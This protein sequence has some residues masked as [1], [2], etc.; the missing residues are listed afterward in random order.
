MVDY[1]FEELIPFLEE[2]KTEFEQENN[3]EMSRK[4]V[5]EF[6]NSMIELEESPGEAK[7][8]DVKIDSRELV[9][10]IKKAG[11]FYNKNGIPYVYYKARYNGA[12]KIGNVI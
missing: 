9:L 6:I 8:W 7:N 2:K 1:A 12:Y 3:I 11:K 4:G 5:L 10:K